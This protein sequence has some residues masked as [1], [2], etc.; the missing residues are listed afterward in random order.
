M[1]KIK[2]ALALISLLLICSLIYGYTQKVRGDQFEIVAL[3]NERLA[4]EMNAQMKM[5]LH[6]AQQQRATAEQ[7]A[8]MQHQLLEQMKK[9]SK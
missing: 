8:L 4:N 3:E 5:A 2:I 1:I 6:V 9:N 7:H